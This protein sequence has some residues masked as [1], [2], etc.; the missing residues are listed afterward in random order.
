MARLLRQRRWCACI[1]NVHGAKKKGVLKNTKFKTGFGLIVPG[2]TD[3][4]RFN[5]S[6]EQ[7]KKKCLRLEF[8]FIMF[9]VLSGL[10]SYRS[11]RKAGALFYYLKERV[12]AHLKF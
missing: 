10:Y 2:G 11:N 7:K 4:C 5:F 3:F 9:P 12:F 6:V 8:H 1:N